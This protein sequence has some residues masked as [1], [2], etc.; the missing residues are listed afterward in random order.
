[1]RGRLAKTAVAYVARGAGS[2][3][4]S[5][6]TADDALARTVQHYLQRT[7]VLGS[8]EFLAQLGC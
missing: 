1:V 6:V 2:L 8:P 4:A 7:A 3:V 5:I